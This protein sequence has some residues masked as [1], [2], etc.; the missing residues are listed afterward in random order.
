MWAHAMSGDLRS[1]SWLAGCLV[2]LDAWLI[3]GLVASCAAWLVDWL[4]VG[5][6]V[7]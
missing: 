3:G 6:L 1:L 2:Y 4:V 5:A 7:S